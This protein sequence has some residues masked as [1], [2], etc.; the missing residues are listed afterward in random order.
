MD[1]ATLQGLIE[2][3]AGM[4]VEEIA[5]MIADTGKVSDPD[6]LA[7]WLFAKAQGLL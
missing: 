7:R 1:E 5:A 4:A 2:G 3:I 6:T